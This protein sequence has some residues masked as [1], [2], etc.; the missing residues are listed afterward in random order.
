MTNIHQKSNKMKYYLLIFFLF[1]SLMLK[2]QNLTGVVF[3]LEKDKKEALIGATVH[4]LNTKTSTTTDVEGKFSI[5]RSKSN[6]LIISF[7]GYKSDTIKITNET[8]LEILL[9]SENQLQEVVVRSTSTVLDKLSPIQT[10]IITSKALAKAACCNLSES[11]ETNASV[12]VSYA[13]AVTGAKQ[14]QMLGLSGTYVQMNVENVPSLRG[15]ASTFGL[16]YIPGTWIQSIDVGKGSGSVVNGHESMT[17]QMNIELQKPDLSEKIYLNTYVNSLGRGEVNLNLAKILN[18]KWSVGLLTH[19]SALQ[20]ALDQNKDN[21]FDLPKYKQAN[22]INRWKYQSEKM[23]AQFGI[24]ILHDDRLGGEISVNPLNL[25]SVKYEFSNSTNRFEVFS[26]IAKLYQSK[27]YRGLGWILNG[28]LHDSK[29]MFGFKPYN[30]KQ[31][32]LYSNLVYQDII[33]NTNH[34]YKAG[35]SFLV[36]D[37]FEIYGDLIRKRTEIVPGAFAEYSFKYLDKLTSVLGTRIDYHNLYGFNFIPRLHVLYSVNK[38]IDLRFSAGKGFR[39]PNPLAEYFGNLVS[40]RIVQFL[41]AEIKP[42]VSWNY[43]ISA[44]KYFGKNNLVIDFYRTDFKNQ[45]IAEMEHFFHLYFYNLHGKSFSNSAQ[46]ELNLVPVNRVEVKLA[47]RYLDVKQSYGRLYDESVLLPKMFINKDRILFNIG[48]SLPY[49]K[50]KADFTWQ[51]NGSRRVPLEA[52]NQNVLHTTYV[53]MQTTTAP[54]FFNINAQ[55]TRN[56]RRWELYLGGENLNNFTQKNPIKGADVP[57][58]TQFDAGLVWGP[59]VGRIIYFGT[60]YKLGGVR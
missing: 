58:G 1:S 24:K 21:F 7:V 47:Y 13:D 51:W 11:F 8:D 36:D 40:S 27:P 53:N 46:I 17:G 20:T 28:A 42:E 2:S 35:T 57:F 9:L 37:Y 45:L 4:W 14:I 49:D 12:S 3:G 43:G 56:F 31:K 29:T 54:A 18:K 48:Y 50:W 55:V 60:R 38:N 5:A 59:V 10:E 33:G 52:E 39:V 23:M 26:K 32:T 16:N 6:Q 22:F 41:D 15:L 30:G 34:S 19:G 44:T 25:N